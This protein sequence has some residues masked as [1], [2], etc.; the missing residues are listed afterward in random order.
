[1]TSEYDRRAAI[2]VA[3]RAGR[4]RSEIAE[5]LKLST[6]TVYAVANRYFSSEA[7]EAGSGDATRK[8]HDRSMSRRRSQ[9]FVERLQ[10]LVDEDSSQPTRALAA[11][12]NVGATTIR[13]ALKE[14]LR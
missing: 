1:M 4:S 7:D 2:I 11:K 14:D 13:Q 10:D 12:L 5:F 8:T 9:D 3:L 6:S